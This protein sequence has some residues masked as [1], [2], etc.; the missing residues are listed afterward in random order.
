MAGESME[1]ARAV[2]I[3][4]S[5]AAHAAAVA[6]AAQDWPVVPLPSQQLQE[7]DAAELSD[8]DDDD[9]DAELSDDEGHGDDD[10]DV[11]DTPYPMRS[12]HFALSDIDGLIFERET[13]PLALRLARL[14][15]AYP[16]SGRLGAV[17]ASAAAVGDLEKREFHA[18]DGGCG[19]T[20]C[21]ICLEDFDD[22]EEVSV[23]PCARGHE[24]H[25]GCITKWLGRSKTCPLCRHELPAGGVVNH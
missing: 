17:G 9:D 5:A 22:G 21:A 2:A 20:G 3:E 6:A 7:H 8:D 1:L 4:N 13:N 11:D 23:M 24:F 15:E 18:G 12:R 25:P 10:V 19:V 14:R 16:R